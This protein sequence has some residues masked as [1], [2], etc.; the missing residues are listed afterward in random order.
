M[1]AEQLSKQSEAE[2][3][4]PVLDLRDHTHANAATRK[5]FLTTL[6]TSLETYGFL[7]LSGHG[8]AREQFSQAFQASQAFFNLSATAKHACSVPESLGNRGYVGLGGEKA[9]GAKAADLKEFFHVGQPRPPVTA[10]L[11]PNTW[12]T[13]SLLPQFA[14]T[15]LALFSELEQVAYRVLG[16]IEEALDLEK[17]CLQAWIEGGNSI[18]RLIHYPPLPASLPPNA[19]RAA[20]HADINLITLLC[21]GTGGGLEVQR[22]DGTWLPV[23]ALAGQLVVNVG[24][25]LQLATEGRLRS[26]PHRVVNPADP[27]LASSSRYAM[28]F[29]VHPRS[30]V[31][32][33]P[34]A[35]APT[36]AGRFLTSRLTAIQDT[37]PHLPQPANEG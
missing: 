29:F 21:E 23:R 4:L 27:A 33:N 37:P 7:V 19:V 12:P 15:M 24:D 26:T 20:P 17:R 14:E 5:R 31:V 30:D 6:T 13:P 22:P 10:D 3:C 34:Q 36:T 9:V 25:M 28:P 11:A 2:A 8:I 32:L 16:A 1:A 18:L 35:A